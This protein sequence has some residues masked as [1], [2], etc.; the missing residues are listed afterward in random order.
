[1]ERHPLDIVGDALF[2][3]MPVTAHDSYTWRPEY[4]V[5]KVLWKT[6]VKTT[7]PRKALSNFK[8]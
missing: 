6:P 5:E 2:G 8:T 4:S 7:Y 1:M 3:L